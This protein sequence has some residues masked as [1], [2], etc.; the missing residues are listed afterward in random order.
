MAA[1]TGLQALPTF[2]GEELIHVV[3]ESPR[4]STPKFKYD[5]ELGVMTLARP[6]PLGLVYPYDWGFVTRLT[7]CAATG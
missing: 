3:I 7:S 4:G 6:L 5:P 2:A 1:L